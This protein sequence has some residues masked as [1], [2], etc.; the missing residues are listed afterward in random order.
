MI[1]KTP[2]PPLQ[3]SKEKIN[4]IVHCRQVREKKM[5]VKSRYVDE[6]E[7]TPT[8]VVDIDDEVV[9]K[10][11]PSLI[12]KNSKNSFTG[13]GEGKVFEKVVLSES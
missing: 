4:L 7:M 3:G 5:L 6:E 9:V 8:Y 11:A 13:K 12:I 2:S 10:E 1:L